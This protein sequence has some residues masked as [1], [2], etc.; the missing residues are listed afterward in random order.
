MPSPALK[1][2]IYTGLAAG[3]GVYILAMFACG[4]ADCGPPRW[5]DDFEIT[6]FG[7]YWTLGSVLLLSLPPCVAVAL[8][9]RKLVMRDDLD[10]AADWLKGGRS[11]ADYV[12]S[13]S[14][15][16]TALL[17]GGLL[18]SRGLGAGE[19]RIVHAAEA[20]SGAVAGLEPGMR[21]EVHGFPAKKALKLVHFGLATSF[22]P[23]VATQ[24]VS[25]KDAKLAMQAMP[26]V[27]GEPAAAAPAP[28][29]PPPPPVP[30]AIVVESSDTQADFAVDPNGE[31][32][33]QGLVTSDPPATRMG[34]GK[35]GLAE[36]HP[37]IYVRANATPT[38]DIFAGVFVL[39]AGAAAIVAQLR[40]KKFTTDLD[41]EVARNAGAS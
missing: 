22:I 9:R 16:A 20:E 24:P 15:A 29:A 10:I 27:G 35:I 36:D 21:V 13:A 39:L 41:R 11:P 28:D 37:V 4:N 40:P 3:C 38:R 6:A 14:F 2:H 23:L 33:A 32:V 19:T 8:S 17:V 26:P 31:I 18:L 12:W 7:R 1:R 30:P 34:A 25:K 5:L